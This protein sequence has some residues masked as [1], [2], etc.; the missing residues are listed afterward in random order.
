MG[1]ALEAR[2]VGQ[3]AVCRQVRRDPRGDRAGDAYRHGQDAQIQARSQGL[4]ARPVVA[5]QHAHLVVRL[6]EPGAEEPAH[7]AAPAH[8][9]HARPRPRRPPPQG[10]QL[11]G[12]RLAEHCPEKVLDVIRV[13]PGLDRLGAPRREQVLLPRRVKSGQV[14]LLFD[15][16]DLL[17]DPPPLRQQGH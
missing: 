10:P 14:L 11:P 13:Q 1:L 16:G 2:D 8:D 12:P 4:D 17:D 7:A 9:E 3:D 15:L 5:I 6:R